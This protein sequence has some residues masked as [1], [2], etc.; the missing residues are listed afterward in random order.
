MGI[1]EDMIPDLLSIQWW[2]C[3]PS[4]TSKFPKSARL[5]KTF[6]EAIG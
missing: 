4:L 6:V 1:V 5:R 2:M 3:A